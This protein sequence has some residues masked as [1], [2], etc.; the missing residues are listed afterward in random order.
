MSQDDLHRIFVQCPGCESLARAVW[1]SADQGF[2]FEEH[3]EPPP[4][5][6]LSGEA[7]PPPACSG[8]DQPVPEPEQQALIAHFGL[9][10]EDA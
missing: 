4:E 10:E 8:S 3:P 5:E 9:E 2:R 6:G 1:N 7:A